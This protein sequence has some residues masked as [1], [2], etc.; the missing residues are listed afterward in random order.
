MVSESGNSLD[1][2]FSKGL[3]LAFSPVMVKLLR[4]LLQPSPSFAD[5]AS[6]LQMDTLL[7]AK[8]LHIVN[9]SS[10]GFKEKVTDLERAVINIGV[11]ELFKLVLALSLQKKLN[12][13]YERSPR[14]IF[15]DWRLT[16][17]AALA[18]EAIAG[19]LCPQERQEAYLV[20]M[21]KDLPLFLAF[22][23]KDVPPFLQ[24]ER[25]ATLPAEGQFAEELVNWGQS[26]QEMARDIFLFWGFS[27][28]MAEAA[29]V[30]HDY[31]NVSAYPPIAQ[32]VI[33]AT[34]WAEL[35]HAPQADLPALFLFEMNLASEFGISSNEMMAFRGDCAGRFNRLLDQLN[36]RQTDQAVRIHD[37]S[38]TQLQSHYFLALGTLGRDI[39]ETAQGLAALLQRQLRLI[40][41]IKDWDLRIDLTGAGEKNVFRCRGDHG[42]ITDIS[43]RKV[44]PPKEDW[45]QIPVV[46]DKRDF[47]TLL[48][49]PHL[50]RHEEE[51]SLPMF[52]SMVA[53][54]LEEHH[55]LM[56]KRGNSA[57]FENLPFV[58]ARLDK[59]GRLK[60]ASGAFLDVFKLEEVPVGMPAS[61]L[62]RRHL[63]ID[64]PPLED[65]GN[66]GKRSGF[67]LSVPEGHFPGTPL[68][69]S[70]VCLTDGKD[71]SCLFIGDVTRM[72][73]LQ[74]LALA[75]QGLLGA[76]F[77]T[78]NEQVCLLDGE[79]RI[80]WTDE[81]C[82][83]LLG[84]NI[85][86]L[87]KPEAAF[88]NAKSGSAG[89]WNKSFL[90]SLVN[91]TKVQ[92][93][94]TLSGALVP[95]ML[96]FSPLESKTERQYLLIL[97][98][99]PVAQT[100]HIP[101]EQQKQPPPA[102]GK[103]SLTDLYGYS[104]FHMLLKYTTE[105]AKKQQC[106]TGIIFCDI[107]G[108][109]KFNAL[110]GCQKG[111][112][113]L[114]RVAGCLAENCRPGQDHA[115]R[116]GSDKFAVVVH[117]ATKD[118]LENFA[119]GIQQQVQQRCGDD[120]VLN[121]GLVLAAPEDTPKARLDAARRASELAASEP[122]RIAWAE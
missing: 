25:Y 76:L 55:S 105:Q 50:S 12:P 53:L 89:Q 103:D 40:W 61:D 86:N 48:V 92:A 82:R 11:N 19:R 56:A 2:T 115:C 71:D 15:G 75:H 16:F 99:S 91:S 1:I 114:R 35:L 51:S 70:R 27:D 88:Q 95:Y 62:L 63:D 24:Q 49:P 85:F 79:G 120:I 78:L 37:Q 10:Y 68:Y 98:L 18:A 113:M 72:N 43:E 13:A 5:I 116:Y 23:Q 41:N 104:Q 28:A 97:H 31:A 100:Q 77:E 20:G 39:P 38:L 69:V 30:H 57:D 94:L 90:T 3:Q 59:E 54:L 47:G 64:L 7:T 102:K 108:L 117:R 119:A 58:M 14:V 29:A 110:H 26:H 33:Y 83:E 22:C 66:E 80:V 122:G 60:Q 73:S 84:R 106:D 52:M 65:D 45:L 93:M 44:P 112:T 21:L 109:H 36:I 74:A 87:S 34:R 4:T 32:S 81:S 67:F 101:G 46:C 17:W 6:Y 107:E 118:L 9:T 42:L 111:D 96:I 121:I 8:V